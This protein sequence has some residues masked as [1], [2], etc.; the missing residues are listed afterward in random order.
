VELASFLQR[1]QTNVPDVQIVIPMS[2]R[3]MIHVDVAIATSHFLLIQRTRALL[4]A[5]FAV[6]SN[7]FARLDVFTEYWPRMKTDFSFLSFPKNNFS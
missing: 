5:S 6:Y 7:W 4:W 1:A 3:V 2:M